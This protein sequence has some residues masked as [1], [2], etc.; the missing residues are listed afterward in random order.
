MRLLDLIAQG[1]SIPIRADDGRVLPTAERFKNDVRAC[2]LRYV[3]SDELVR[4][5]TQQ[6]D[7]NLTPV[8]I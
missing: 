2:P 6:A 7:V 4:C 3:L 8:W 1:C 5:A